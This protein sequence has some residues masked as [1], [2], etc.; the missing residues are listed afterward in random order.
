MAWGVKCPENDMFIVMASLCWRCSPERD[1]PTS[2]MFEDTWNIRR[3][4]E[5]ALPERIGE[6]TYPY[7]FSND[8]GEGSSICAPKRRM[9][10]PV[11]VFEV[12]I[13]CCREQ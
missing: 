4:C 3:Y 12:E 10:C 7:P 13:G 2:D 11:K 6:I 5:A 1:S 9:E 8:F